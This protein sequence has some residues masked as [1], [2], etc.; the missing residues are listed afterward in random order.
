MRLLLDSHVTLWAATGDRRIPRPVRD[1][2]ADARTRVTVSVASMWE[3]ALKAH[4][5]KLRLPDDPM[6]FMRDVI[7][8]FGFD[9]LP[10]YERHVAGL[11]ELPELHSDPFDRMLLAQ[12]LVEDLELVTAD[13]VMRSYPVRTLW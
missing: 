2:I 5:G 1:V 11:A 9:V 8:E 10:V 4:A 13:E 3:I 7:D 12:A 6:A